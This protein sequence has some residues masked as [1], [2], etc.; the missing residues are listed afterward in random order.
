MTA[1]R[2]DDLVLQVRLTAPDV[3]AGLLRTVLGQTRLARLFPIWMMLTAGMAASALV[4]AFRGGVLPWPLVAFFGVLVTVV[5]VGLGAVA[6]IGDRMYDALP[7][8]EATWRF[9]DRGLT[10]SSG[11]AET[12][13]PWGDVTWQQRESRVLVH[14]TPTA[15]HVLPMA[16]MSD[17]ERDAVLGWLAERARPMPIPKRP[18]LFPL[19]ALGLGVATALLIRAFVL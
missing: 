1:E 18:W 8:P 10:L 14:P 19:I 5:G 6:R 16:E 4:Q 3:R 7:S 17:A 9:R 11:A 2:R 12:T 15:F 13:L